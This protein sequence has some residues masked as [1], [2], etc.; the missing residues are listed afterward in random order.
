MSEFTFQ[1]IKTYV[2]AKLHQ[3]NRVR[4]KYSQCLM[5]ITLQLIH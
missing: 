5:E 2:D 3:L 1:A 4:L